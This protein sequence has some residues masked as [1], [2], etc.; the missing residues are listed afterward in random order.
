MNGASHRCG[1][2]A[3]CCLDVSLGNAEETGWR[4]VA[5]SA[6]VVIIPQ[7]VKVVKGILVCPAAFATDDEVFVAVAA[8]DGVPQAEA[9]SAL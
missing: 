8:F 9:A 3:L 2:M 1:S 5:S 7:A 6:F 4:T